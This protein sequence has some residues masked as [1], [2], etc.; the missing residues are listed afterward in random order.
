MYGNTVHST[1]HRT[2]LVIEMLH[3][4]RKVHSM[5]YCNCMYGWHGGF[6]STY[7]V[8]KLCTQL[9]WWAMITL[10]QKNPCPR[11]H[12]LRFIEEDVCLLLNLEDEKSRNLLTLVLCVISNAYDPHFDD[13][14]FDQQIVQY[15]PSDLI[16]LGVIKK[17][18]M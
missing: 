2:A 6:K 17:S 13:T 7:D 14:I 16:Q 8:K 4:Y 15:V 11:P 1:M 5:K 12:I 3:V 9:L 18:C 10:I